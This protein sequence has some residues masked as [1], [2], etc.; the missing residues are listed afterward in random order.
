[1]DP[2]GELFVK[3]KPDLE[4]FAKEV[5]TGTASSV[6]GALGGV[7]TASRTAL[8]GVVA[9]GTGLISVAT[10]LDEA[11]DKI[12]TQTGATGAELDA[13][14]ASFETVSKNVPSDMD[15][16]S[17]AIA[18]LN[19]TLGLTG[20]E[21]EAA[22]AQALNLSRVTGEDLNGILKSSSQIFNQFGLSAT[23]QA[24]LLDD[25]FR[26]SQA[27]GVGVTE[28]LSVVNKGGA[29]FE[30]LGLNLSESA[31]LV[32]L[33]GKNGVAPT[34]VMRALTRVMSNA[35]K[36]G[37]PAAEALAHVEESIKN[38]GSEADAVAIAM[39]AFGA[40]AGPKLAKQIRDGT[41]SLDDLDAKMGKGS[42]TIN[43]VALETAD[44]AE[45]FQT[46]KNT[47]AVSLGP[48]ANTL[49]ASFGKAASDLAPALVIVVNA[50]TPLLEMVTSLPTPVLAAGAGILA[51]GSVMGKIVGPIGAVIKI[52]KS[53]TTVLMANPWMAVAAAVIALVIV[54]V[55]NWDKIKEAVRIAIEW[56]KGIIDRVM[57][58][59]SIAWQAVWDKIG[60]VVTAVWDA[61]KLI[62]DTA[63]SVIWGYIKFQFNLWKTIIT[64]TLKVIEAV[65]T[66]V[67]DAIT[68]VVTT[69]VAVVSAIF[70]AAQ[71]AI[72]TTWETIKSVVT[73][74]INA[75]VGF[76]TGIPGRVARVAS[77]LFSGVASAVT[78]AW[79]GIKT[80]ISNA[81][82]AIVGFVT[83]IPGKIG[84]ML[85][86]FAT[87]GKNLAGAIFDGVSNG[88]GNLLNKGAEIAKKFVNAIIN[89]VNS[90][91]IDK[92]NRMLEFTI[93]LP[94]VDDIK[95][96]PPDIPR[97]PTFDTGG[98]V[99]GRR[100][101]P[102]LVLAHGGETVLPTHKQS[103]SAAMNSVTGA[104]GD[105]PAIVIQSMTVGSTRDAQDIM[106]AV[107]R[108]AWGWRVR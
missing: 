43:A 52:V 90:N 41:V 6:S 96:N 7:Q 37:V 44:A 76:V 22:A 2:I 31:D 77:T 88:V 50:I 27:T 30:Q 69:A 103:Y 13:L 25:F 12:R 56:V 106:I 65:F 105:G 83:G 17:T 20:P 47:L 82:G 33:L 75:V 32:G 45:T 54:I 61:I 46:L 86:D 14:T 21:L 59:I 4:G 87:M 84:N 48:A 24:T 53:L 51:F 62:V 68:A 101:S 60:G 64:T 5:A 39:E 29:T 102:Q 94:F 63:L 93:A 70:S 40:K 104:G 1:M 16:V 74:A 73:G 58:A 95:V 23:D 34:E 19:Q 92:V 38:A 8:A 71:S 78:T 49:F 67:W 99:P 81:I 91:L 42:D 3:I 85:S 107:D 57:L 72:T 98:V 100:G 80:T 79:E 26:T 11:Y 18:T 35:A 9:V 15:S 28:L 36:E 89:F 55:K 108:A 97:I 66:A 10:N